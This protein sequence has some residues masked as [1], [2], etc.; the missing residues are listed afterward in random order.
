MKKN[1]FISIT[2]S[3]IFLNSF[4]L[5][6]NLR[7]QKTKQLS[8]LNITTR[9]ELFVDYFLIDKMNGTRLM[10]HE[11]RDEGPVLQFDKPWEGPFCGYCTVIKT[12]EKYQ[13]YYR[14]LPT[15]GRDGSSVEVTCYAESNDGIHWTKPD[16]ELFEVDGTLKN[17]VILA[18]TAPVT[19]NFSPFLDTRSGV[20]PEQR[21]KALGGTRESGLIAFV[22]RMAFTGKNFGKRLFLKKVF[23]I[24]RMSHF[25]PKMKTVTSVIFAPGQKRITVDSAL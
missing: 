15:A 18:N 24:H 6:L 12:E 20:I 25:G 4:F 7:A 2:I 17:N 14:G 8:P 13:L 10:L 19:H 22:S 16:L 3:L 1:I 11:P 23:L 5:D 9:R 21:Y